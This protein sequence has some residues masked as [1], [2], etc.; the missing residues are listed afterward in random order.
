[1][2]PKLQKYLHTKG[3]SL[4]DVLHVDIHSFQPE[5]GHLPN[6]WGKGI[7]ILYLLGDKEQRGFAKR[8]AASINM[9]LAHTIPYFPRAVVVEHPKLPT[10]LAHDDSNAMLEWSRHYG[11]LGILL[12]LPTRRVGNQWELTCPET[13]LYDAIVGALCTELRQRN[14]LTA[15]K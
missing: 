1:L 5:Y 6:K 14:I 12:E 8:M 15:D 4:G 3:N 7:N 10:T 11:G 13:K 2:Y 9:T